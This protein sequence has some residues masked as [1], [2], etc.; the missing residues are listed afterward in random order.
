MPPVWSFIG[1]ICQV[2]MQGLGDHGEDIALVGVKRSH[3][4][5]EG[6]PVGKL[7]EKVT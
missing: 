4:G 6:V 1:K 5:W 2:L 3:S 7:S